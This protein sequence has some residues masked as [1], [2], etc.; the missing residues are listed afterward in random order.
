MEGMQLKFR[1]LLLF[2][3]A[4]PLLLLPSISTAANNKAILIG[5]SQ[6]EDSEINDL[7]Y[8]DE[9]VKSFSSI[10]LNIA[11][12]KKSDVTI[13]LNNQAR[14]TAIMN[15]VVDLVKK[16]QKD[17]LDSLI[18]M[19]AGHG[20][21]D[22]IYS[23]NTNSFL[24]PYDAMVSQFFHEGNSGAIS[25]ET[26]INR[27][28]LV[29]Q[30]SA[31]KAKSVIIILDSCY[32]GAKDFG[33]L[34]AMNMGFAVSYNKSN[35][36]VAERGLTVIKKTGNVI[37]E[38]KIAFLASSKNNQVAA[39]YKE[40]Q[41]G[42]LS[43]CI[44]EY[45]NSLRKA[46]PNNDSV[47]VTIGSLY[48]N[49]STLFDNVQVRGASLSSI[50]QPVLFPIPSYNEVSE[51]SLFS[52][53]GIKL[54][55]EPPVQLAPRVDLPIWVAAA[56]TPPKQAEQ[57]FQKPLAPSVPVSAFEQKP[58]KPTVAA[59]PKAADPQTVPQK[60][61]APVV[62]ALPTL[63]KPESPKSVVISDPVKTPV[64]TAPAKLPETQKTTVAAMPAKPAVPK[65]EPPKPVVQ[66]PILPA[67]EQQKVVVAAVEPPA[68]KQPELHKAATAQPV[69]PKPGTI[70][71]IT[72]PANAEISVNGEKAG[73][74]HD[75]LPLVAGSHLISF[76]IKE[77]NY[78]HTINV[79]VK[80]G[81][82]QKINMY[83][84]GSIGV[85]A[86]SSVPGKEIPVLAVYLDDKYI[87]N[88]KSRIALDQIVSGTHRLK[89]K[90]GDVVKERQ[91][92]IR[93]D[94]PLLV[95][96]KITKE[97]SRQAVVPDDGVSSVTF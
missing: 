60:V 6:Y 88:T 11:N 30:L 85:E 86:Y 68:P 83:L 44:F 54:P 24:A 95:R 84:R 47:N 29:K 81:S 59:T 23:H 33:E 80:D 70:E 41:H 19:F 14:K 15:A 87:G 71:I 69:V 79:N 72:D 36:D 94:S 76:Y 73:R 66:E 9:D 91:V 20:I 90:T 27:A 45:I 62:T 12:Y 82:H 32:S 65:P 35:P 18:F 75:V 64:P 42:A 93:Q 77:T 28:W 51:M 16:S 25:N 37:T 8:A 4:Y 3:L 50:H 34:F 52:V 31:V 78:K 55:P 53:R 38:K 46:T 49:I 26:F 21:P 43:Y 67:I 22:N 89:V 56:D 92:E 40:L 97:P 13:L 1:L 48:S 2:M 17:P 5:V 7:A 63:Q 10:L 57:K 58:A 61:A 39:E 74:D 96:Y